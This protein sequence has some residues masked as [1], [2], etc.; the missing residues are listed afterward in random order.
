[1]E[2]HQAI[3]RLQSVGQEHLLAHWPSLDSNQQMKLLQDIASLN[4]DFFF[5]QKELLNKKA[6]Y[7]EHFPW[8]P[9]QDF[10]YA[11]NVLHQER[12]KRRISQGNVGC[13]I[14][15]GGQGTRLGWDHP[16]GTFLVSLIKRKSLF[17]LFAEKTIA[18]GLQAG[19]KLPIAIMTSPTND[20]E[21]RNFFAQHQFFNLDPE[22]IDFFIQSEL[23]FLNDEGNL[24]LE[25]PTQVA[26]A[27][28]GNGLS[29]KHFW[30][31]GIG[32]KWEH[33][34]I[35]SINVVLIDNPLADP[36][37]A[38]LVGFNQASRDEI[39]IKCIKRTD[40][41]EKV[42]ILVKELERVHVVEYTEFPKEEMEGRN[43][44]GNLKYPCANLSLFCIDCRFIKRNLTHFAHL[45]LHVVKKRAK[46]ISL[47][48]GD[49]W[50]FEFFIFD[51]LPLANSIHALIYPREQCFSPL[52]NLSGKHGLEEVQKALQH[53]DILT[54]STIS[55][56]PI[57]HFHPFELAQDFYYPSS[58]LLAKWKGKH[59]PNEAYILP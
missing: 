24:F 35:Q 45:P 8:I 53:L 18:A 44:E 22:Q 56:M 21:T 42:G 51:I 33:I 54:F 34:G 29:L 13:L 17:Q 20:E 55:G 49:V 4:L 1:M 37:D 46:S 36:F 39:T 10:S 47:K 26:K 9:F 2:Y 6:I 23:P 57:S 48:E 7:S 58:T 43:A 16:K 40:P 59:L 25:T 5:Q 41:Q 27:P 38:E 31:S 12:G 3:K 15:A 28:A 30:E 19:R 11:G 14:I 50:K 52:K 32:P